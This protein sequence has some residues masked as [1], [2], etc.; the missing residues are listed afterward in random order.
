MRTFD[1]EDGGG[2]RETN[3]RQQRGA[4][5]LTLTDVTLTYRLSPTPSPRQPETTLFTLVHMIHK[6]PSLL[7]YSLASGTLGSGQL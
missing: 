5:S 3:I 6:F 1:G 2:Q 7:P 4:C